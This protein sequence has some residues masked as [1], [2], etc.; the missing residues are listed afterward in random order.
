MKKHGFY[1]CLLVAGVLLTTAC[2]D[3]DADE[4][5]LPRNDEANIAAFVIRTGEATITG[6]ISDRTGR[7]QLPCPTELFD[8]LKNAVADVTVSEGAAIS[9]DP[10]QPHDYTAENGVEY[11]VTA[12]N[13]TTVRKYRVEAVPTIITPAITRLWRKSCAE[14][15][16][17]TPA[18]SDCAIAFSGKD[19]VTFDRAVFNP[20]GQ[21]IGTLNT[22]G[23]PN[24]MLISLSNDQNG[25]LVATVALFGDKADDSGTPDTGNMNNVKGSTIWA[26]KAGWDKAPVKLYEN[27][28]ENV[29]RYMSVAGDIGGEAV[30]TVRAAALTQ[31][32]IH[33]CFSVVDGI[34][35]GTRRD[36]AVEYPSTDGCWGQLVSPC[37][38]DPDGWFF[39]WDSR[40]SASG[41]APEGTRFGTAVYSR[42][43]I[44]GKDYELYGT[45]VDDGILTEFGLGGGSQYGT[46]STGHV[47]GFRF[48]GADYAVVSSSGWDAAYITIQAAD[49]NNDYIQRTQRFEAYQPNTCSAYRYDKDKQTGEILFLSV[50]HEII[51]YQI[52]KGAR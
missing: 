8:Q 4:P 5:A 36:F 21:K 13:G 41:S 31:P 45:M 44:G 38:G 23:L 50:N 32:Q 25:V 33:H 52:T 2:S 34:W 51:R 20:E 40:Q 15:G 43:G 47:R 27:S 37:S 16:I 35:P 42:Q 24:D 19:F 11:T 46:L 10:T 48:D 6:K 29:C 9:P 22:T 28:N 26:W 7:I 39:I 30:L 14:L 49:D 17:G 1:A 3:N 12:E 18:I